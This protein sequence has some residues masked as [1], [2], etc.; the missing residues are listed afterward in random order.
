MKQLAV[1][2]IFLVFFAFQ[3]S[4][5]QEKVE[6]TPE[7]PMPVFIMAGQSNMVG[8]SAKANL[9]KLPA[10]LQKPYSQVMFTE[11]W[12]KKFTPLVPKN[13]IGPEFGFGQTFS[14]ATG[15]KIGIIK[16]A[17]GGTSLK[18]HWNPDPNLY[19]KEKSIGELYKR[20]TT[21]VVEIKKENP[22]IKIMGMCW[23]QG[24]ADSRYGRISEK[25]YRDMLE[26]FIEGCRKEIG[27]PDMA[28]VCGRVVPPKDWPNR[29]SVRKAQESVTLKNYAWVDCDT[30]ELGKD[31]LHFTINGQLDIG[32]GMAEAMEKL[33][34][35]QEK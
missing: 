24:E 18:H 4:N 17:S 3:N 16:L 7:K 15:Q 19:N 2:L 35:K 28:F 14:T 9:E 29:E 30:F 11:F 27:E 34:K 25:E 21:Y 13:D 5:S 32:K 10:E 22:N 31:N 1:I 26:M 33:L 23:M 12:N 8:V 20:L 6:A